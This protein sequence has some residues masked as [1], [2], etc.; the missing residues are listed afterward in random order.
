MTLLE[1]IIVGIALLCVFVGVIK[2][3]PVLLIAVAAI[4]V[5]RIIRGDRSL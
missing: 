3:I 5:I 1:M 2:L 4:V